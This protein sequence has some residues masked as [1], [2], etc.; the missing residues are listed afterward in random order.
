MSEHLIVR[1]G[2][3]F[4]QNR[5]SE[6][7]T[8]ASDPKANAFLNDIENH[9]HAFVLAC[10]MDRQT[11][12]E[13]AWLIPY[14]IGELL[15]DYSFS[16]LLKLSLENTVNI[17]NE[18]SLHRHNNNMAGVFYSAVQR[19]KNQY[20]GNA[21]IIWANKPSSS[22]VVY[23]FLQFD[24]IGIKIATMTTNILV[25][26]FNIP[27]SDYYSIDVSP[28]VHVKRVM[29]RA[30]LVDSP[31][32]DNNLIIYKARELCPEFPGIIDYSLWEIGRKWC[33]PSNPDCKNC[34]P[35]NEC[36]K[37]IND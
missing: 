13:R 2:R 4:F 21:S 7:E 18:N 23:R 1:L 19:I 17:F 29:S 35:A 37:R 12:A 36:E 14:K 33:R 32:A 15:G 16:A 30:G 6:T 11:K 26:H 8:F 3:E 24:G 22:S 10:C 5:N 34:K 28:D 25:R 27:L 9:P 31:N 20:D